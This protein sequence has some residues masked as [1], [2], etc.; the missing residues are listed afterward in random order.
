MKRANQICFCRWTQSQEDIN[1]DKKVCMKVQEE[2]LR[3]ILLSFSLQGDSL[4]EECLMGKEIITYTIVHTSDLM[5]PLIF[6]MI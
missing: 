3:E 6:G 2:Q 5:L 1:R 4:M